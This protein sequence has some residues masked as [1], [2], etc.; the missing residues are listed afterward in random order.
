MSGELS[1]NTHI[2]IGVRPKGV[3]TVIADWSHCPSRS[4]WRGRS[5]KH[6]TATWASHCVRRR[7]SCLQ[8]AAETPRP[9]RSDFCRECSAHLIQEQWMKSSTRK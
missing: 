9:S 3:M 4:R 5:A 6:E 8:A 2:L 1:Y 7:R